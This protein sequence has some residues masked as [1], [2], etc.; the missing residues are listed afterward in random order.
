MEETKTS[1]LD[2]Y[3]YAYYGKKVNLTLMSGEVLR[4]RIED[5]D[6]EFILI[7]NS[8]ELLVEKLKKL[9]L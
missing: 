3:L 8:L 4:G 5:M 7:D 1:L 9:I 2:D 6:K